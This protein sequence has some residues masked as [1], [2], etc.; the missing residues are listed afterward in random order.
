MEILGGKVLYSLLKATGQ[1]SC[2]SLRKCPRKH[3]AFVD[4]T[5]KNVVRKFN[6]S[7]KSQSESFLLEFQS[8][9]FVK[10]TRNTE[11]FF[12]KDRP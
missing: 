5:A 4:H 2:A 8:G 6:L 10:A 9:L 7:V 12:A 11:R 3:R 1:Y